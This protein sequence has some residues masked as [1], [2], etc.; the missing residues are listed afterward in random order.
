MPAQRNY[1]T[2]ILS[3]KD[4]KEWTELLENLGKKDIYFTPEYA[5]IYEESYGKEIDAAFCGRANLFFYGNETRYILYP[6][7]KRELSA[8]DAF[9]GEKNLRDIVS[10][11]GY[12]GPIGN[13]ENRELVGKF[14]EEFNNFCK[15]ENIISEFT[16]FHPLIR[17]YESFEQVEKR[18]NTVYIDLGKSAETLLAEMDRK[19]RNLLRKAEKNNVQIE[20]SEKKKDI[21]AFSELYLKTMAKAKASPIYMLPLK[22]FENTVESLGKKIALFVAR[23]NEEIISAALIMHKYDYVHYHFSGSDPE[24]LNLSSNNLLI[25]KVALWGK[26]NN[27]KYF[28]LGGGLGASETDPLYHFK[29]GFSKDRATFC[30]RNIIHNEKVYNEL[31]EKKEAFNRTQGVESKKGYFPAYRA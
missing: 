31:R 16:R 24:K 4:S 29:A 27:Y 7:I 23:H 15:K 14:L 9:K 8:L 3:A 18:N 1:E 12:N 22:F 17:N 11:Y 5:K 10:P 21:G 28:H 13:L 6:F 25:Y 30:T 20:I 19:T 26:E 2:R